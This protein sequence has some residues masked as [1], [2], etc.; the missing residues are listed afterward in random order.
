VTIRV[1]YDEPKLNQQNGNIVKGVPKDWSRRINNVN[2]VPKPNL[3]HCTYY[4]QI[5]HQINECPFIQNNVKK[6]FSKH[7]QNLNPKLPE[8]HG[9]FELE[10]VYHDKVKIP[11]ILIR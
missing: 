3:P 4:H 5:G 10:D 11:N 8:D 2:K 7:F 9:D 6:G 1:R